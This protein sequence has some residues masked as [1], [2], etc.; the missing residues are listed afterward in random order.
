MA[1]EVGAEGGKDF[2][3]QLRGSEN[4]L[5][6]KIIQCKAE[7]PQ[8]TFEAARYSFIQ[9]PIDNTWYVPEYTPHSAV[10]FCFIF[11]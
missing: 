4:T 5:W 1:R 9:C 6:I 8:N 10:V 7:C 3:F 11:I 2:Y